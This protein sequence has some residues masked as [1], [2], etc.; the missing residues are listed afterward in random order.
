MRSRPL[1]FFLYF[2]DGVW[3]GSSEQLLLLLLFLLGGLL[4]PL[5]PFGS[6]KNIFCPSNT[7]HIYDTCLA[8]GLAPRKLFLAHTF[9]GTSWTC[10]HTS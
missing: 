8:H 9:F 1:F 6:R 4:L 3:V 2:G 5:S 10:R 7:P